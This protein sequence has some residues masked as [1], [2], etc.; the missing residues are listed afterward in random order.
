MGAFSRG[1]QPRGEYKASDHDFGSTEQ[2]IPCGSVDEDTA[3]LSVTFGSSAKTSDF[4]VDP[5]AAC[6][7]GLTTQEQ[8]AVERGQLKMDN[9]PE[10]SGV[11]TQ[12]LHRRVQLVDT[13]GKPIQVLYYPPYHSKDNPLERC[14][15]ILEL[16]WNGTQLRDAETMLEWAKRM[17][18]KGLKAVVELR[19]KVY[20]KGVTLSK[21]TLQAVE[22]RLQRNPLLPKWDILIHPTRAT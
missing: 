17:T 11:R 6:W 12:F 18:W 9:G 4:M 13:L 19:R 22:A 2:Y 5:L 16:H 1:G 20:A 8:P 21:T 15:G 14:W 3:Q 10:S 7:H